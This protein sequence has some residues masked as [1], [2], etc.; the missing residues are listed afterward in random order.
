MDIGNSVRKAIADHESGDLDPAMI[1]A[2]N[3]ID[4]TA[5]KVY[6]NLTGNAVRFK[7]LLREN[8]LNV[9]EP[10]APTI[11][12]VET[13]FPVQIQSPRSS[14]RA[15]DF[16]DILY[17]IHRCNHNHGE[18]LPVG[19]ELLPDALGKLPGTRMTFDKNLAGQ[20][21]VRFSDRI[22]FGMLAAAL[23]SPANADQKIPDGYHMTYAS[24]TGDI[25]VRLDNDWW[26]RAADFTAI[27]AMDQKRTRVKLDFS[28]V[29]PAP[30]AP[31]S[32]PRNANRQQQR[33]RRH[34]G[35]A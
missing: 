4:G 19:F 14:G 11:N 31:P 1:H 33:R 2:C 27:T 20:W 32:A 10:M 7:K 23:L 34:T 12:L 21:V 3:A 8:C 16:A 22:I 18:P 30:S 15:L 26:G 28:N 13:V 5:A 9:I 29:M 24:V 35:A 17:V 25:R 6:P